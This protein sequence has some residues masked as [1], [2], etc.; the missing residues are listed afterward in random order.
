MPQPPPSRNAPC[1]CGS[2]RKFKKC[3]G[4]H[5]S[6]IS[7]DAILSSRYIERLFARSPGCTDLLNDMRAF[8]G[9]RLVFRYNR[10]ISGR[11]SFYIDADMRKLVFNSAI[12]S[13]NITSNR[14]LPAAAH[15]LLHLQLRRLTFPLI[16]S[17]D[18]D[19][20]HM[21][22]SGDVV[23]KINKT[24]NV[25]EHQIFVNDFTVMGFA[26]SE[27]LAAENDSDNYEEHSKEG[28]FKSLNDRFKWIVWSWW[29]LEFLRHYISM[30]HGRTAAKT[31][32]QSA[33]HWGTKAC[34]PEFGVCVEQI[35]QWIMV[36]RYRS[37]EG[38]APALSSLFAL[39]QLP[40][41]TSFCVLEP[42]ADLDGPR[43]RLL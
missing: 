17:V 28:D 32:A 21:R 42:S 13:L 2:G 5:A 35:R 23:D 4:A 7:N 29:A 20:I 36:E 12:I 15:E 37:P 22:V 6:A 40:P 41:I 3:C 8:Y 34:G 10:R 33:A 24:T 31:L 14:V 18:L 9:P 30:S 16:R 1:P 19:D 43:M 26:L 11:S 27:F 25:I 39:M 38:Y